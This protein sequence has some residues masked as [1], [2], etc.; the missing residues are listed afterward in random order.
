MPICVDY[1]QRETSTPPKRKHTKMAMRAA[2]SQLVP[3]FYGFWRIF[4][5]SYSAFHIR[6]N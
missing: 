5:E 6:L 4:I 2:G 3:A 1:Q